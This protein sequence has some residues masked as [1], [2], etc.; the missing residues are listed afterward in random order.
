MSRSE[1]DSDKL[2]SAPI[3]VPPASTTL[4]R[5]TPMIRQTTRQTTVAG[6]AVLGA[7]SWLVIGGAGCSGTPPGEFI[8]VQN[9]VPDAMCTIPATLGTVYRGEGVLDVR[10]SDG[11]ELFPVLQNN[12]PAPGAGQSVDANRIA[13]S[14]FDVDVAVPANASSNPVTDLIN[15]LRPAGARPDPLVQFSTLTS[16]SVASGGGNTASSVGVVP[17]DLVRKLQE[18]NVLTATNHFWIL[19]TVHARGATLVG[20]VRSDG[21][22]YPIELCDGCLIVDQ[23][24]CPVAAASGSAC[25]IGQDQSVGCCESAGQLVCPSV[26]A[27]K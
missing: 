11:Y 8:I 14:G 3:S 10:L 7:L 5:D 24:A 25:N 20:T 1:I 12:F 13:I 19:A 26:V 4:E 15:G 6:W 21:F 17:G 22:R 23:G 16:G 2:L 27:S 18:Q 9:Q